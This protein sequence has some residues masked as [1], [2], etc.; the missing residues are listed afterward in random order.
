MARYG[1]SVTESRDGS[2]K[3]GWKHKRDAV[4]DCKSKKD[5][6]LAL[7]ERTGKVNVANN[8][9]E[10]RGVTFADFAAGLWQK[11]LENRKVKPSTAYSYQS[12]LT[13][14]L[15]PEFGETRLD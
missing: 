8:Q 12:M 7:A 1:Q 5:A 2:S 6:L 14:Y 3:S 10:G 4:P 15:L 11:Y 9:E 13:N